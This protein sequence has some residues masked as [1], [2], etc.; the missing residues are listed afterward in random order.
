M[1]DDQELKA[2]KDETLDADLDIDTDEDLSLEDNIDDL[3]SFG[4]EEES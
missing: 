2:G 4:V 3:S 1:N